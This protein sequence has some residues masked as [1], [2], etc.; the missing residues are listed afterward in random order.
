MSDISGIRVEICLPMTASDG[1]AFTSEA[2]GWFRDETVRLMDELE[3]TEG[4]WMT[5]SERYRWVV[6]VVRSERQVAVLLEFARELRR[7]FGIDAIYVEHHP[8]T[9]TLVTGD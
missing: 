6:W 4:P 2:W 5:R 9:F 3:N 8:I 7:R 1:E